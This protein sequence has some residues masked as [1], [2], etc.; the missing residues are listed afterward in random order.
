MLPMIEQ[1]QIAD[2]YNS[3]EPWD[4]PHNSEL[5]STPIEM[6]QCPGRRSLF[7]DRLPAATSYFAVVGP[8]TAWP[9]DRGLHLSEITDGRDQTIM[10]L[11]AAGLNVSWGEPRDLTYEEAVEILSSPS[12]DRVVHTGGV[13]AA[14]A[15]GKVRFLPV[16]MN[17]KMAEALLTAHGGD[18]FDW[19]NFEHDARPKVEPLNRVAPIAFV[20]VALAPMYRL[21]RKRPALAPGS[22]NRGGDV[23]PR[24]PRFEEPGAKG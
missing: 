20:I 4:S 23:M 10:L 9:P 19:N 17:R 22:S 7:E 24:H 16:P 8:Q 14:F 1:S 18:Q 3:A 6:F 11:E 15:D 13:N 2:A 12:D 5:L 21:L